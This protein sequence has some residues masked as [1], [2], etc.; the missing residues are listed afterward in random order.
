MEPYQDK[1]NYDIAFHR[2]GNGP[3]KINIVLFLVDYI[4]ISHISWQ[5][6]YQ[7]NHH[8]YYA[9]NSFCNLEQ[10]LENNCHIVYRP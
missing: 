8:M 10:T 4:H 5:T 9:I 7:D 3:T 1:R 6:S 2:D